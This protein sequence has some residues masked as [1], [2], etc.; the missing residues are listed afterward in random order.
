VL[1]PTTRASV[2]VHHP[3]DERWFTGTRVLPGLGRLTGAEGPDDDPSSVRLVASDALPPGLALLDAP[4]IDSVVEANRDLARQLLSA[5]DL[6]LF[7][8]TAAR[9]ADAVPWDLLREAS[10]RGTS[11]AIVLDRVPPEA[12]EEVRGHLASMLAEQGLGTAP[13]FTVVETALVNGLLPET[14]IG[15]LRSW[16]Q[17]LA[18]DAKARATVIKR[19]LT[20]ALDSLGDRAGLLAAA[21]AQQEN[22]IEGLRAS[23]ATA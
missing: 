21:T 11:V 2:L 6:W 3:E 5:A 10:D 16:L 19:T 17:S 13:V 14:E 20:G 8:T 12:M 15:R 1:R 7:V 9:Y 23:A 22:A 18:Q 4:D